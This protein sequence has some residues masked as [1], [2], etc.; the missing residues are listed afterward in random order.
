MTLPTL[1]TRTA[2]FVAGDGLA[3]QVWYTFLY[4]LWNV[5]GG[6]SGLAETGIVYFDGQSLVA[7]QALA[8]NFG[9]QNPTGT[10]SSTEVMMGLASGLSNTFSVQTSS[11]VLITVCGEVANSTG[12]HGATVSV[13]YDSST[14]PAHGD[15]VTG[16]ELG[17]QTVSNVNAGA[18]IPFS[19]TGLVQLDPGF[20]YWIDVGLSANG[21]GT[22]T[23]TNV[24]TTYLTTLFLPIPI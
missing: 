6:A 8:A 20:T 21:G 5:L 2:P 24:S 14:P 10:A 1:P 17:V 23:V 9:A 19:I 4:S 18:K 12:T 3:S 16:N 13:L 22:A 11:N 7:T 15:A